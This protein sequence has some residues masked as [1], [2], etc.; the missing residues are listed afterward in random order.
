VKEH[1]VENMLQFYKIHIVVQKIF[2]QLESRVITALLM[3][4]GVHID[5]VD[6]GMPQK[7][8]PHLPLSNPSKVNGAYSGSVVATPFSAAHL[9]MTKIWPR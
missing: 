5:R 4:I 9:R 6:D 1:I 2:E 7:T 8:V 3:K